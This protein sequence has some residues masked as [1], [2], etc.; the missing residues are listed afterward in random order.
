MTFPAHSEHEW[1]SELELE[2][3]DS[4]S[5]LLASLNSNGA[6]LLG[7]SGLEIS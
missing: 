7:K 2:S 3:P 1:S 4:Y 5:R 6:R